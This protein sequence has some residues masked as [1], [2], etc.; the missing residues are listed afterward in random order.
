MIATRWS[1][2]ADAPRLAAI[3]G[4]AWR[5]AYAGVIPAPALLRMAEGGG[6]RWWR[7]R[8]AAGRRALVV[9][10]GGTVH[11]YAWL[12]PCRGTEAAGTG[13]I[14][15]L[16]LDPPAQGTGLGR[17]LF[18]AARA[19]LAEA[20]MRRLVVRSLARNAAGCRFYRA[21]GGREAGRVATAVGGR[22]L[23]EIAFVWD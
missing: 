9:E 13:E 15:E 14:Y 22:R 8:I 19:R 2:T 7:R 5:H 6:E 3:R 10:L 17:R 12:G 1:E 11:G 4:R 18:E 20:G 21:L 16:Y 23:E